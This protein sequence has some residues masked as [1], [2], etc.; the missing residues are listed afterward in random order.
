M[1]A[2]FARTAKAREAKGALRKSK[3][4]AKKQ[5]LQVLPWPYRPTHL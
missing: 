1:L 3:G 2:T 5:G 4:D